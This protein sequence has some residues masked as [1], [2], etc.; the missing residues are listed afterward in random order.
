MNDLLLDV[1]NDIRRDAGV[2]ALEKLH[3]DLQLR[4]DIGFDS[5]E[6]AVLVVKLE[7]AFGVDIFAEGAVVTIGEVQDQ[8]HV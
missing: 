5:L 6:L 1:I 3:R 8:I 7:A 4:E 2:P